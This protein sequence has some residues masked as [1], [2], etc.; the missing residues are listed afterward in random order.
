MLYLAGRASRGCFDPAPV[1]PSVRVISHYP[2]G[3]PGGY[4]G[5]ARR[6]EA[7]WPPGKHGDIGLGMLI[8][9]FNVDGLAKGLYSTS[10]AS[11]ELISLDSA[12][13][14][15]WREQYADA[16]V[17]I[18]ICADVNQACRGRG[19]STVSPTCPYPGRGTAGY[20]AWLW[21]I[22]AGLAGSVYGGASQHA[23]GAG[24]QQ[25]ANLRHLFTVAMGMPVGA[26]SPRAED[27]P[28]SLP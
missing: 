9:A 27:G 21:S 22:S 26:V 28:G 10:E 8:I 25:D 6:Q 18:L 19:A 20:A 5:G 24:R 17:L 4:R 7:V 16:P 2:L 1:R 15:I 13:L 11:T 23:S 3:R 12:Y 14:D